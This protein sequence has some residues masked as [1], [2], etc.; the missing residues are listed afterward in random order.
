M[1]SLR[2]ACS[3]AIFSSTTDGLPLLSEPCIC[4]RKS[5]L[6]G[7][8]HLLAANLDLAS[9]VRDPVTLQ[10]AY[11]PFDLAV[12]LDQTDLHG[13]AEFGEA[14]LELLDRGDVEYTCL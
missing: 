14:G 5:A 10:P 13:I 1:T 9:P 11:G 4:L 8:G 12:G 2:F 6:F 3:S 7:G